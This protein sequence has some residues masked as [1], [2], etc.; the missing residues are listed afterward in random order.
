[1]AENGKDKEKINELDVYVKVL[2][3]DAKSLD[4][5]KSYVTTLRSEMGYLRKEVEN[6]WIITERLREYRATS[7]SDVKGLNEKVERAFTKL[8]TLSGK[9]D[10]I[11][12]DYPEIREVFRSIKKKFIA[13][14]ATAIV[15]SIFIG[16]GLYLYL[17][18]R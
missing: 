15:L 8:N 5:Y 2:Q 11:N 10:K 9:I 17:S 4:E 3:E 12:K 1:M 7:D 14:I 6:L 18:V 16:A 13:V